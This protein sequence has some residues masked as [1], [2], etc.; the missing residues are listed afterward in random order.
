VSAEEAEQVKRDAEAVQALL[1]KLT[2]R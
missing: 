1:T 2:E